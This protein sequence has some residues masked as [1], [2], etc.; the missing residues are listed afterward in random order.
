M[1]HSCQL[2]TGFRVLE[3]CAGRGMG[4]AATAS[5]AQ[6][7]KCTRTCHALTLAWSRWQSAA[8]IR[9]RPGC[10]CRRGDGAFHGRTG[11]GGWTMSG[12][13]MPPAR[14]A[15][16]CLPARTWQPPTMPPWSRGRCGSARV[17]FGAMRF[18]P[19]IAPGAASP[20]RATSPRPRR[21]KLS[22][23]VNRSPRPSPSRDWHYA[24]TRRR[25]WHL[26]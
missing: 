22:R 21:T 15:I 25:L 5:P 1:A 13:P 17:T 26:S 20:L 12:L 4:S 24:V 14:I 18:S 2:I 11:R 3:L 6:P 9:S 23:P 19:A 8:T 16:A 10:G 7:G